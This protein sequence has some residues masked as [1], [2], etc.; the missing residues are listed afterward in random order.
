MMDRNLKNASKFLFKS[1]LLDLH[2]NFQV[3]KNASQLRKFFVKVP[4]IRS[5]L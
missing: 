5:N 1:S 3:V 2:T 4:I